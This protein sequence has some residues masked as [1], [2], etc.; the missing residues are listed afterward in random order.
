MKERI[1]N[2]LKKAKPQRRKLHVHLRHIERISLRHAHKFIVRRFDNFKLVRRNVLGWVL[3]VLAFSGVGYWQSGV[4]AQQYSTKLPAEGGIYTEAVYGLFDNLN[5]IYAT[6]PAEKSA[7][8]LMFASLLQYDENN[9]LVGELAQSWSQDSEGKTYTVRLRETAKWQDD[10]LITADDV[11]F[12]FNLIKDANTN[13]PLYSGWR[14]ISVEKVD[15]KTVKFILPVSY[16]GFLDSLT[17]GILPHHILKDVSPSEMRSIEFNRAPQVVSGPFKY[18]DLTTV[19]T[20]KTHFLL[21]LAANEK[22]VLGKPKLKGFQLHA[23][24]KIESLPNAFTSQEVASVSGVSQLQIASFGNSEDY[25]RKESP[26]YNGVYAFLKTDSVYLS[27]TKVRQALQYATNQSAILEMLGDG[28][29]SLSG[30]LLPEQIVSN[31]GQPNNDIEKAKQLLD[32]AGWTVGPDGKRQKNGEILRL[33]VVTVNSSDYP[34]V[35]EKIMEQWSQLGIEF[36]SSVVSTDDVQQNVISTRAYDVLIYEIAIGRDPDVYAYWDSSQANAQGLN[37]SDYKSARA[38]SE[39]VGARTSLDPALR[40]IK[41]QA[42]IEQW[43]N[44]APAIALYRPSLTY[45]QNK[46]VE[47]FTARSLVDATDR[48]FN[49]R[50]WSATRDQIK[51]T[52]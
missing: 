2:Q 15:D 41:Y 8:R 19:D 51:L 18:Q 4:S 17:V 24:S 37:L 10:V 30:P 33:N 11:V 6:T 42:F 5:P 49:V 13:S 52:R 38:D 47:S 21:Q 12:T 25:V 34:A 36:T 3:V 9:D 29:Q 45:I 43:M 35:A 44:D 26:L 22:Y 50:Y 1:L 46:S 14:N 40:S 39:L 16:A 7:S 28:V 48:Y 20:D 27:D 23:Y 31:T 32:A